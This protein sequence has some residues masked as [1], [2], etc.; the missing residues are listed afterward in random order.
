MALPTSNW[1][2]KL[3]DQRG[4][5]L[6][7]IPATAAHAWRKGGAHYVLVHWEGEGVTVDPLTQGMQPVYPS[8][9]VLALLGRG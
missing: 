9:R 5:T 2:H 4:T 7:V 1:Y 3:V 8:P 6:I